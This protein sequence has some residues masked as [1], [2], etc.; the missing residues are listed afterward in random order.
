MNCMGKDVL[1]KA[2]QQTIRFCSHLQLN[3]G[4]QKC[5]T[6]TPHRRPGLRPPLQ[7]ALERRRG[8]C[9]HETTRCSRRL[10]IE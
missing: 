8:T 3:S 10:E 4:E 7:A 1:K 2:G 9:S 5:S 6:Q